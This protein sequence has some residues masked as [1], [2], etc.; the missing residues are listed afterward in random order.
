M[1]DVASF[2]SAALVAE[3]EQSRAERSAANVLAAARVAAQRVRWV[4][5]GGALAVVWGVRA[6]RASRIVER[7]GSI[8]LEVHAWSR[9]HAIHDSRTNRCRCGCPC[10]VAAAFNWL[11]SATL[12]P[13]NVLH[14]GGEYTR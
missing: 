2:T 10:H 12:L 9:S 14:C 6:S 11:C 4:V 3:L 13:L 7:L 1:S 8:M 5:S